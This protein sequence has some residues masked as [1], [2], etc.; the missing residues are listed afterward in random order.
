[1]KVCTLVLALL[2]FTHVKAEPVKADK[3]NTGMRIVGMSPYLV[4][5]MAAV[6]ITGCVMRR[7][8]EGEIDG[9]E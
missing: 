8:S 2:I 7:R 5:V 9:I 4:A 1:M 6:C 3:K